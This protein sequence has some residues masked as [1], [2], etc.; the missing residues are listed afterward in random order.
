MGDEK[1]AQVALTIIEIQAILGSLDACPIQGR[2]SRVAAASLEAKLD[3]ALA[4][5]GGPVPD[6]TPRLVEVP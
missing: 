6:V 2:A 3:R 4:Q 1:T 5:F